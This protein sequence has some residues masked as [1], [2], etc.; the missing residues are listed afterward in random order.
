M[1]QDLLN[2][3]AHLTSGTSA[4][5]GNEVEQEKEQ[6]EQV[7]KLTSSE[8][9]LKKKAAKEKHEMVEM[10]SLELANLQLK[11]EAFS[12]QEKLETCCKQHEYGAIKDLEQEVFEKY[13]R[14]RRADPETAIIIM[15]NLAAFAHNHGK[16][17]KDGG[18][19]MEA[20]K[21]Y[22]LNLQCVRNV[23][24]DDV[25]ETL[26]PS[27]ER[28]F[29]QWLSTNAI[30]EIYR[31]LGLQD[32]AKCY[33]GMLV[34]VIKK[35]VQSTDA[36][37]DGRSQ[38]EWQVSLGKCYVSI[39]DLS[40]DA[41]E[42]D[43][44]LEKALCAFAEAESLAAAELAQAS[45]G[46][47]GMARVSHMNLASDIGSCLYAK[48]FLEYTLDEDG[49]VVRPEAGLLHAT[50]LRLEANYDTANQSHS[51]H[52]AKF[53]LWQQAKLTFMISRDVASDMKAVVFLTL[54]CWMKLLGAYAVC[55]KCG[56]SRGEPDAS[57]VSS[58]ERTKR[59]ELATKL[60]MPF[61]MCFDENDTLTPMSACGRCMLVRSES[62]FANSVA[63]YILISLR[64]LPDF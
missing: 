52:F 30:S 58:E 28:I 48:A 29:Q 10:L 62:S 26:W 9:S 27:Q 4:K 1:K 23:D 7:C 34:D 8:R 33:F 17:L 53:A 43:E 55:G 60:G 5:T 12:L 13:L 21:A 31:Q 64:W 19:L 47:S 56:K 3:L 46:L 45:P 18:H 51:A 40:S 16:L 20:I 49:H 25:A 42:R 11:K 15:Q 32:K 57:K 44:S 38:L 41:T 39:A 63:I 22:E 24:G 61:E 37:K 36:S 54:W 14:F 2:C 50:K 35:A 6:E 59:E